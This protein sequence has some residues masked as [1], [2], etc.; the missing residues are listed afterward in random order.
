[1]LSK[2]VWDNVAQ[3]NYL[4]NIGPEDAAM[5]LKENNPHSFVLVSLGQDCTKQ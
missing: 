3:E 5:I 2:S 4:C 1:M